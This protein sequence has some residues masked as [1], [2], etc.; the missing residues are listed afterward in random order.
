LA[1]L[2]AGVA[3]VLLDAAG[4]NTARR[5]GISYAWM[6][7][8]SLA[9]YAGLGLW[10]TSFA[11]VW[12]ATVSAAIVA[13]ADVTLGTEV[14]YRAGVLQWPTGRPTPSQWLRG[15]LTA[16]FLMT[17]TAFFAGLSITPGAW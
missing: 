11:T 1:T 10:V 7:P 13:V 15:G 4:A 6:L 14:A 5:L 9:F 3:I 16:V 17:F 2:C 12:H 8:I